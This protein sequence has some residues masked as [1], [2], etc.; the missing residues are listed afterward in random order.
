MPKSVLPKAESEQASARVTVEMRSV[1]REGRS[2]FMWLLRPKCRAARKTGFARTE[3]RVHKNTT[4]RQK[5]T[6][7]LL[8][9]RHRRAHARRA[10]QDARA[11]AAKQPARARF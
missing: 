7:R 11:R 6:L 8:E 10:E 5:K 9:A 4:L 3:I 2:P 1:L